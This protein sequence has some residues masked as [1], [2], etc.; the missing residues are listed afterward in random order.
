M[1]SFSAP[2]RFVKAVQHFPNLDNVG[3]QRRVVRLADQEQIEDTLDEVLYFRGG[4]AGD[5]DVVRKVL[6]RRSTA[7]FG[8]CLRDGFGRAAQLVS[9][10]RILTR[11]TM[12]DRIEPQQ[13]GS[14]LLPDTEVAERAHAS[15]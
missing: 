4:A 1:L 5:R 10:S 2:E 12:D 14:R 13:E 7:A 11:D 8:Q 9:E 6:V 3:S 15:R